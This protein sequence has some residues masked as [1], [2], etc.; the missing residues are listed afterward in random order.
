MSLAFANCWQTKRS[1]SSL[2]CCASAPHQPSYLWHR[3]IGLHR[4]TRRAISNGNTVTR[5]N[6]FRKYSLWFFALNPTQVE[7]DRF[8]PWLVLYLIMHLMLLFVD[9]LS[10][11]F[12]LH[13][14]HPRSR[15]TQSQALAWLQLYRLKFSLT[16][17]FFSCSQLSQ[18]NVAYACSSIYYCRVQ[19]TRK[20]STIFSCAGL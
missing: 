15:T 14:V 10:M 4:S 6:M 11:I 9:K 3:L 12:G 13:A 2:C 20:P 18:N 17:Q 19:V 8:V 7:L 1:S 16:V 5:N